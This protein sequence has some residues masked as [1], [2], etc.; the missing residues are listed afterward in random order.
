MRYAREAEAVIVQSIARSDDPRQLAR[1]PALIRAV[2]LAMLAQAGPAVDPAELALFPGRAPRL[3]AH[4]LG[5]GGRRMARGVWPKA[6]GA[7]FMLPTDAKEPPG[8]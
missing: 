2:V 5:V 3:T 6:A 7:P 1:V 8:S 4:I